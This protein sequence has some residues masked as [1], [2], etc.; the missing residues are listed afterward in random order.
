MQDEFDKRREAM[1]S[2]IQRRIEEMEREMKEKLKQ[3][4]D[5]HLD[6][7]ELIKKNH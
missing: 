3:Q 4:M 6:E 1:D 7:I 2:E 5:T